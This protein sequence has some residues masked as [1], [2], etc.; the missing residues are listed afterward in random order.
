MDLWSCEDVTFCFNG[1]PIRPLSSSAQ[2]TWIWVQSPGDTIITHGSFL[3]QG[4]GDELYQMLL[5][6]KA[7]RRGRF[8]IMGTFTN[9]N[10]G[11]T[12][13]L[14]IIVRKWMVSTDPGNIIFRDD[15][16]N[17]MELFVQEYK[18]DAIASSI[19]P[20]F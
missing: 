17:E 14:F 1:T 5:A 2:M 18:A 11:D 6:F 20:E 8:G 12:M 10:S 4:I 13:P 7:G 15:P 16:E 19:C 3:I 9:P